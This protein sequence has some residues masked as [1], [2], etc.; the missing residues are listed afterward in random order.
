MDYEIDNMDNQYDEEKE[1]DFED[2]GSVLGEHKK[3]FIILGLFALAFI[4][5]FVLY[6]FK[7]ISLLVANCIVLPML[8]IAF[9]AWAY[10][11]RRGI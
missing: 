2:K 10:Y 3:M 8:L 4:V 6:A 1:R 9:I 5:V 11:R 7:V